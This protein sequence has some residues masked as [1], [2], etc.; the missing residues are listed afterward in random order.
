MLPTVL[1]LNPQNTEVIQ[2]TELQDE[3]T[4]QFL[5]N[6][7]VTATLYDRRG[8]PDP[9]FQNIVLSYVP[10]TDATYQGQVPAT[11]NPSLGGGYTVV[12]IAEQAGVQAKFSI[13]AIVQLRKQ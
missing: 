11:F 2:V 12:L 1:Y 4:G 3:V 13:P 5:I 10:G 6:A 9:I 7:N 8:N